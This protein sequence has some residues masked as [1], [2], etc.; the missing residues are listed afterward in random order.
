MCRGTSHLSN[1]RVPTV[2][3]LLPKADVQSGGTAEERNWGFW[4]DFDKA[5]FD[6]ARSIQ[7]AHTQ[8]KTSLP[9]I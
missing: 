8:D 4:P 7:R 3:S 6:F 1:S 5:V 9:R 2:R